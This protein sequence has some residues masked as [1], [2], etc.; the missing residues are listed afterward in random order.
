VSRLLAAFLLLCS[1][2][3]AQSRTLNAEAAQAE[4]AHFLSDLVKLDTQD[5]PGNESKV[6]E[7]I[8]AVL[9]KEGIEAELLKTDAGRDSVVARLKGDGSAR[10]LLI[11]GHEDVVPVDRSHWTVE[12]FAA[13]EK[14]GYIYGRGA[15][16][17]KAMDAA[18]LEVFLQLKRMNI[19]LKRDVI[20]LAEASE[21]MSSTA[22]MNTLVAKYWD[23]L[24]C[25]FALNE[26]GGGLVENGRVK[27]IAVATAEKMPRGAKLMASG[28]SGHGS[29]P[30]VDN[31]VIHLAAAVAK[32]GTWDTPSRLNETTAEFFKRLATISPPDEA[33]WYRDPLNPQ[34]QAILRVKKPQYYSMLRTSVVPT[35]LKAGI[36]S[37]VIPPTAEATLDIRMLPDEDVQNFPNLLAQAINDPQVKVV[38]EIDKLN[39]PAAPAS[40]LGTVMFAAL[41]HA[42]KKVLPDSITLPTMTTG[43]TDSAFL[44]AKGVQAYG[45]GVPATEEDG[46][47]VHGNDE[48]LEIKQLGTFVQFLFAAVTE[49]AGK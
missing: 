23:K 14:D 31:A 44:R 4:A 30:R 47:T 37:N 3:F 13:I 18:N 11:M 15:K 34:T 42:Q 22:G 21:E 43:A 6:A 28:S 26:G 5:P 2:S 27:Y 40:K 39:M 24:D 19:P 16:D 10:P 7:Y 45:I 32:A 46:R 49:V 35:M 8:K 41:E 29:I 20:L 38:A 48:R 12:P 36:K 33:A 9:A 25:E 17:D 1:L